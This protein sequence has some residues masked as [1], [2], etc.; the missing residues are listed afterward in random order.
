MLGLRKRPCRDYIESSTF[1]GNEYERATSPVPLIVSRSCTIFVLIDGML[2]AQGALV[3]TLTLQRSAMAPSLRRKR[4]VLLSPPPIKSSLSYIQPRFVSGP[5]SRSDGAREIPV[6]PAMSADNMRGSYR[7]SIASRHSMSYFRKT[8]RLITPRE[9]A[10][11][12][13]ILRIG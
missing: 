12:K 4:Y 7:P 9:W 11:G 6:R 2:S 1:M 3:L 10:G 5:I 13:W 8:R